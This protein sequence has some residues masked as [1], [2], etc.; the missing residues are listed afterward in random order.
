MAGGLSLRGKVDEG[1]T[2]LV[3]DRSDAAERLELVLQLGLLGVVVDVA[4]VDT[5][6]SRLLAA[7]IGLRRGTVPGGVSVR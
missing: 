6:A 4:D 7:L 3:R 2:L 5:P 1:E